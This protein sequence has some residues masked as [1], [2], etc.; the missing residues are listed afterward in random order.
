MAAHNFGH[1]SQANFS[2]F[3]GDARISLSSP[4]YLISTACIIML[5]QQSNDAASAQN[6]IIIKTAE[7]WWSQSA[8]SR[9]LFLVVFC[10]F[11]YTK[12]NKPLKEIKWNRHEN[13]QR[14]AKKLKNFREGRQRSW[15]N[16]DNCCIFEYSR[17]WTWKDLQTKSNF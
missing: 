9:L 4:C 7:E 8:A 6:N 15:N 10:V 13:K 5:W 2:E 11:G 12:K 1:K 3:I 14:L 16:E 17:H